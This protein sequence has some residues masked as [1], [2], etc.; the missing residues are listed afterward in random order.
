MPGMFD[1][2]DEDRTESASAHR[3]EEF[4]KQGTVALSREVLSVALLLSVGFA[5]QFG[6]T[7]FTQDFGDLTHTFFQFDRVTAISREQVSQSLMTALTWWG[8]AVTPFFAM[9]LVG[10]IVAA[11][12]QVG[13]YLTWEPLQPNFE[14]INP[15]NNV[16]KL[17]SWQGAMEGAKSLLKL[18]LGV[19][20]AYSFFRGQLPN[21]ALYFQ[22]NTQENTVLL[23]STVGKLFFSLVL[24]F[25]VIAILD[26]VYQRYQLEQQMK[27]SKREAKEEFKMREGDPLIKS[28]IRGVQRRIAR[29]RM[30]EAVPKADVIVTNPTHFAVALY[31]DLEDGPA[32]KVVAKGMDHL[33][34]RI[35]EVAKQ[36]GVPIVENKP[37]ARAL[38]KEV[39]IGHF[40]PRELFKAV[41]QVLSYVY[42]LKGRKVGARAAA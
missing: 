21:A 15:L 12:A 7:H 13:W 42:R 5:F 14:R 38:Y 20:V 6:L 25:A 4:R 29:R 17:L 32:P 30:M 40:I 10:G 37:L 24:S 3:R 2:N 34:L 23:L 33:A 11:A 41:A 16:Q 31:Y 39:E 35:R 36:H 18:G 26:Y 27:V 19:L 22:K 8:R 9:A 1:E 28:R